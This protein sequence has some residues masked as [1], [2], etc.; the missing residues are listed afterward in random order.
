MSNPHTPPRLVHHTA[1]H[2]TNVM[3][4][5]PVV[6]SEVQASRHGNDIRIMFRGSK[7]CGDD[8][9]EPIVTDIR[10]PAPPVDT[11]GPRLRPSCDQGGHQRVHFDFVDSQL[12]VTRHCDGQ[13]HKASVR[14]PW[15]AQDLR[16][17][18]D[19]TDDTDSN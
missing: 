12:M 7:L 19:N 8:R 4:D 18:D 10:L 9:R 16:I 14:V 15:L 6:V 13:E 5:V 1:F 2:M 11:S 3:L 17:D